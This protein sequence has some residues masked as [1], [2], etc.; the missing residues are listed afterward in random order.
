MRKSL[1][2]GTFRKRAGIAAAGLA[3]AAAI[4]VPGVAW[5]ND[6]V[7]QGGAVAVQESGPAVP[8]APL[9]TAGCENAIEFSADAVEKMRADGIAVPAT[10][11]TELPDAAGELPTL[12]LQ[13]DENAPT[14]AITVMRDC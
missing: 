13:L 4:T 7:P 14:G 10:P 9:D 11:V 5:A 6:S 12:M 3:V 8:G 1:N 2:T